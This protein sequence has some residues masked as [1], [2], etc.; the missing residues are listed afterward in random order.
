[1][2]IFARTRLIIHDDCL[3]P[4]GLPFVTLN[5][6]GPN[7]QNLYTQIKKLCETIFRAERG[8]VQERNYFWDRSS[9][10]E[11][12]QVK[13]EVVKDLDR[14]TYMIIEIDFDGSA[15]PSKTFG[16]EG[17]ANVRIEG[18]LRTEYPQDTVWQRSI[19]YEIFRVFYHKVIYE[20]T[21]KQFKIKCRDSINSFSEE[22]KSFLNILIHGS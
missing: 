21:R 7:P 4:P 15:K 14:F 3:S 5:Y 2:P 17:K 6:T 13:W 19:F 1:M 10:E 18:I 20:E 12:F 11:K 16:K 9:A 8:E 22:I